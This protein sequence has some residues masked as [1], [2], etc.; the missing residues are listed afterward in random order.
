MISFCIPAYTYA[1]YAVE[2]VKSLTCQDEEFEIILLEDFDL[3][4]A[5]PT[6]TM[7]VDAA[8]SLFLSDSRIR[9]HRNAERLPIQANWNRAVSLARQPYVKLLGADDRIMAGGVA[10]LKRMLKDEPSVQFHGHRARVVDEAGQLLRLQQPFIQGAD[11][12][13]LQPVRALKLKLRQVA[14]FREPV[15]NVFTKAGW[16]AVGGYSDH[17]RFCFDVAFNV[18]LMSR[19]ESCLWNDCVVELRRHRR[20]DGAT[21][22]AD[23]AVADL[24]GVIRTIFNKLGSDLTPE[25]RH[26]GEA[27][28]MYR[29]VELGVARYRREPRHWLSFLW[30]HRNEFRLSPAALQVTAATVLRR[31][32]TGDVQLTWQGR[33]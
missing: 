5:D 22:S 9:W 25:D 7:A 3:L 33:Q 2:A 12:M 19:V 24:Q 31:V 21:L 30:G 11:R 16:E 26:A 27:W 14:R 6:Q 17:F 1:E 28:L 15:C 8:R 23:L 32:R 10:A 13:R 18:E 4:A 20:S 29:I